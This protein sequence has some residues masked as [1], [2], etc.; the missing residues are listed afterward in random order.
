VDVFAAEAE[1]DNAAQ[2]AFGRWHV[3][4]EP[5]ELAGLLSLQRLCKTYRGFASSSQALEVRDGDRTRS[6]R[7]REV[8]VPHCL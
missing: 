5:S 8:I 2:K 6:Q 7:Y 3:A 1:A 4:G